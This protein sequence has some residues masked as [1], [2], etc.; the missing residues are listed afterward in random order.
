MMYEAASN[1]AIKDEKKIKALYD[2]W[3]IRIIMGLFTGYMFYYMTRKAFGALMPDIRAEFM[4]SKADAGMLLSM[5]TAVYAFSKFFSAIISDKVNPKYFMSIGLIVTGLI[6]ILFGFYSSMTM[7]FICQ[8]LNGVFQGWG[9]PPCT[10]SLIYWFDKSNRGKWWSICAMSH[11]AGAMI[12]PI[13]A[14]YLAA[15]Y[16]WKLA[17]IINGSITVVVGF[18]VMFTLTDIPVTLGLPPVDANERKVA[19]EQGSE[20]G[21]VQTLV[22]HLICNKDLILISACAFFVYLLRDSLYSWLPTYLMEVKNYSNLVLANSAQSCF[23]M[24][25]LFG[26]FAAGLITDKYFKGDRLPLIILYIL[27]LLC[28]VCIMWGYSTSSIYIDLSVITLIGFL[29]YGPQVL[30]MM[31]AAEVVA[32]RFAGSA[33]GFASLFAQSGAVFAGGPLGLL[34]DAYG[35]NAYFI[36]MVI[37]CLVILSLILPKI[38]FVGKP[39]ELQQSK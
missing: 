26:M 15:I 19:K 21:F 4:L 3:R 32:K 13:F 25:G 38:L 6:N 16:D 12:I 39:M 2:Y 11:N 31:S 10:K 33:N 36:C 24:G 14:S 20:E 37:S 1:Y 34:M 23:E 28:M 27:G 29:L 17:F 18:V 22:K 5:F 7:L 8:I 9:W 30:V 35:W